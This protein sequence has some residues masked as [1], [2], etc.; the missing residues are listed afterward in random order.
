MMWR[1]ILT[2]RE[3]PYLISVRSS[4]GTLYGKLIINISTSTLEQGIDFSEDEFLEIHKRIFYG[5]QDD[6]EVTGRMLCKTARILEYTY[7]GDIPFRLSLYSPELSRN[8][9]D[10]AFVRGVDSRVQH[11]VCLTVEECSML[12]MALAKAG[13][14]IASKNN[15][16]FAP[17]MMS[18]ELHML[19]FNRRAQKVAAEEIFANFALIQSDIAFLLNEESH[20]DHQC[21]T[22]L[23]RHAASAASLGTVTLITSIEN[24]FLRI[25]FLEAVLDALDLE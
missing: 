18:Q 6:R 3:E 2:F 1:R 17:G 25:S 22:R 23:V 4:N 10:T 7:L 24:S 16:V 21:I 9:S 5:R 11:L 13:H 14:V 20:I 12:S 8:D 15:I 19:W